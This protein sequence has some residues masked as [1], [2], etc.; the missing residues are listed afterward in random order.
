MRGIIVLDGPDCSGKTTLAEMI[1]AKTNG[2]HFHQIYRWKDR[3]F[4]YHTAAL[5]RAIEAAEDRVVVLDRLWMSEAIYGAV[6]RQGTKW[7]HEGRMMDRV[8]RKHGGIYIICSGTPENIGRRHAEMKLKRPEQFSENMQLIAEKFNQMYFGNRNIQ[9]PA[10]YSDHLAKIGGMV[11]RDDTLHYSIESEGQNLE[12]F[13][14]VVMESLEEWRMKQYQPALR[15]VDHNILGH[16]EHAEFLM[17]GDEVNPKS[18]KLRWPFYDYGH[19]SLYLSENLHKIGFDET[20]AMWTN[21]NNS[22]DHIKSLLDEKP[23]K[24]IALGYRAE[25]TLTDHGVT[26]HDSVPH[27]QWVKRFKPATNYAGMLQEAFS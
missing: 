12:L 5:H 23:L 20:K 21:A 17:V 25:D 19:S 14:Q 11:M 24:V 1:V 3:M 7:P 16:L 22:P 26:L 27:P 13:L 15:A 2:L 9:N 18:N 4:T 10:D 6:Y 8:I